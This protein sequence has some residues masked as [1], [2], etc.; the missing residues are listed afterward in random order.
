MI[1][2][3]GRLTQTSHLRDRI[4]WSLQAPAACLVSCY[5]MLASVLI[6][7]DNDDDGDDDSVVV[8]GGWVGVVI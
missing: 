2:N 5:Y 3:Q 4:Q 8:V 1:Q 7:C 6:E